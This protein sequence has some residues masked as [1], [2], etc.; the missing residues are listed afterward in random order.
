MPFLHTCPVTINVCLTSSF[1]RGDKAQCE[2]SKAIT[3][4]F[5]SCTGDWQMNEIQTVICFKLIADMI[6]SEA[7]VMIGAWYF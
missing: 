4:F 6:R 5:H 2:K 3:I 7:Q 1:S